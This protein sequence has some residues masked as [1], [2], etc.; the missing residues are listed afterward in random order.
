MTVMLTLELRR[1]T[2]PATNP[3]PPYLQ[4]T[5]RI[6]RNFYHDLN[7]WVFGIFNLVREEPTRI[8]ASRAMWSDEDVPANCVSRTLLFL[9]MIST[10]KMEG[11]SIC[12][13][14]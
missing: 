13:V 8:S 4:I 9:S 1:G 7:I 5:E 11:N 10:I 14:K 3:A 12:W 6:S 2:R